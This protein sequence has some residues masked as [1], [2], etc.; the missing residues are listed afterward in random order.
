MIQF[1]ESHVAVTAALLAVQRAVQPVVKDKSNPLLKNRYATLDAITDYV[2][3]LLNTNELTL[4]QSVAPLPEHCVSIETMLLHTS[5][6]WVKN[7]VVVPLTKGNAGTSEQQAAGSTITYGRRYG[8]SALLALTTDED[9]DGNGRGQ[10]NQRKAARRASRGIVDATNGAK[11]TTV[12]DVPFPA[13]NGFEQF[14]GQPLKDVPT[15]ALE[16][17]YQRAKD[18]TEK[19]AQLIAKAVEEILEER[20]T[21]N[22]FTTPHPALADV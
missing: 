16:V 21:A 4:L 12:G 8:L 2:R 1:S 15:N 9:D 10:T 13:V 11:A 17:C 20:R 3:P 14:R 18:R 7:A 5:G 6:E 22:D 19:K